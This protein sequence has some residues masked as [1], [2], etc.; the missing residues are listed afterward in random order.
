MKKTIIFIVLFTIICS[1]SSCSK[2]DY[3]KYCDKEDLDLLYKHIV[4]AYELEKSFTIDY[5]YE[6]KLFE[7]TYNLTSSKELKAKVLYEDEKAGF[8]IESTLKERKYSK[9][10]KE[11]TKIKKIEKIINLVGDENSYYY[12]KNVSKAPKYKEYTK[13]KTFENCETKFYDFTKTYNYLRYLNQNKSR[14]ESSFSL[15]QDGNVYTFIYS[16]LTEKIEYQI[17]VDLFEEHKI[18][19]IIYVYQNADKVEKG[20]QKFT[21][22]VKI[23]RPTDYK[24]YFV[25]TN[26]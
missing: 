18:N 20:I 5:E 14:F 16:N 6:Q 8:S 12:T 25:I 21:D 1:L 2:N 19:K 24:K 10:T 26:D 9:H 3:G 17:Y 4:E 11:V 13:S 22:S 23:K 15:F 7:N